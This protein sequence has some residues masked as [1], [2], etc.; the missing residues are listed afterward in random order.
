MFIGH[1]ATAL[2]AKKL[3][4]RP[5]LG[6]YLVDSQYKRH[7]AFT[8]SHLQRMSDKISWTKPLARQL[9]GRAAWQT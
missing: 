7:F 4:P 2:A 9:G 5:S 1:I 8:E 6:A 3:D